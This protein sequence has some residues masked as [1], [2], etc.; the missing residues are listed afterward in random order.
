[1]NKPNA[2]FDYEQAKRNKENQGLNMG[3]HPFGKRPTTAVL[4]WRP[5]KP[6][7]TFEKAFNMRGK[8]QELD[9]KH[10]HAKIMNDCIQTNNLK[11]V[12]EHL[13]PSG[14]LA[15]VKPKSLRRSHS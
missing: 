2:A 13:L 8:Q 10:L 15:W 7:V 12:P 14:E 6:F 1:M 11:H 9:E 5:K 4:A 3:R